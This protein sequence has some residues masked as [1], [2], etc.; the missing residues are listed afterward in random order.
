MSLVTWSWYMSW[1]LMAPVIVRVPVQPCPCSLYDRP[2]ASVSNCFQLSGLQRQ[3]WGVDHWAIV[4]HPNP[5]LCSN[6]R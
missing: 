5:I 4:S 6:K 2:F 1:I 3:G